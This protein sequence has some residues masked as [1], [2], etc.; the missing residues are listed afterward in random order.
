MH[1]TSDVGLIDALGTTVPLGLGYGDSDR[2]VE[3]CCPK[4]DRQMER[5]PCYRTGLTHRSSP[6][7]HCLLARQDMILPVEAVFFCNHRAGGS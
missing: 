5:E 1:L 7:K 2:T 4:S 6:L 3:P